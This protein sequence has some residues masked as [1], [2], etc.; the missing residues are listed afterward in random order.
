M[1]V[2]AV[3]V[4]KRYDL[5]AKLVVSAEAGS[6]LPD[7]YLIIDNGGGF[8]ERNVMRR[9]ALDHMLSRDVL[10][11]VQPGKNLGVAPAWN[12][13]L[14]ACTANDTLIVS[15]DDVTVGR[16]GLAALLAAQE[17][18]LVAVDDQAGWALFVTRP[19]KLIERA[20]HFDEN[21]VRAYYEDNDMS[22]R[23]ALAGVPHVHVSGDA[24]HVSGGTS[25]K[26]VLSGPECR[27]A[28]AA[29]RNNQAYYVSK[30][31]ALP[32]DG[33]TFTVPF[34]GVPPAGWQLRPVTAPKDAG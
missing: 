28:R 8:Y 30:W 11:V 17:N 2:L 31:G 15:N 18:A 19:A 25:A 32:L 24:R 9:R 33:E 20:G 3:P 5:L 26:R 1:L 12:L 23:L 10:T 22:R 27:E 16:D 6:V 14:D 7:R 13:A 21:F 34:N 29:L 4:Y